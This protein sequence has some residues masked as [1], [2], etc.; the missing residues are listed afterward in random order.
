MMTGEMRVWELSDR[1][2]TLA[3]RKR[4]AIFL[5]SQQ[6]SRALVFPT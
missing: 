3:L 6:V 5:G 4:L 2:V 1:K